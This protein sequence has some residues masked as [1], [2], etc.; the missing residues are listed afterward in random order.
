VNSI[1]PDRFRLCRRVSL[2]LFCAL[3]G[4][5]QPVAL[6]AA[7]KPGHATLLANAQAAFAKGRY[8]EVIRLLDS[9]PPGQEPPRAALKL[10]LLSH[11]R[12]GRPEAALKVYARLVPKGASEDQGLLREIAWGVLSSY[13]RDRQEYVRL[14][15]FTALADLG[16]PDAVP[17]LEDGLLDGS[18]PVRVRAA[19]GLG[20]VAERTKRARGKVPTAGLTR[21]GSDPAASVRI[22][23][24]NALGY[25]GGPGVLDLL[26]KMSRAE[27]GPP[28]VFA[29]GALVRLGR[30]DAL[31]DVL[32]AATLPDPDSRM[33]ALGVLGS[34]RHRAG[35]KTLTQAVYD[36]EPAVRAFAAGALGEFGSPEGAAALTH[37][38]G[39]EQPRVRSV[40]AASLGRLRLP[41]SKPLLWQAAR[42]PVPFVRAGGVEG[43]LRTGDKEAL[44]V[45][46]D[47]AQ[48]QDPAVRAAAAQSL[49]QSGQPSALPVLEQL[50]QD[51]QPQPRLTAARA[52]GHIPGGAV[53]A[54]L[55]KALEDTEPAVRLAA[56]GSL[57]QALSR[58]K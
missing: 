1:V 41:D 19:E 42:D 48:H 3:V 34:L 16:H 47:L 24:A 5:L 35:L 26:T 4:G 10:G 27:E 28:G 32:S 21:A 29:A 12:L 54:P 13:A 33:A 15:A 56:A 9:V 46:T 6:P 11:V 38:I 31:E 17:L 30:T 44:L 40:A 20:R 23:A 8:D 52:L 55:K 39:D 49:G 58:P 50:I 14:A 18:T 36:P 45:A 37:A 7:D 22:A 25:T 53:I 2:W 43:L 51:Q 57:L